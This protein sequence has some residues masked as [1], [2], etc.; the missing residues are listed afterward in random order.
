[1]GRR[2][3]KNWRAHVAFAAIAWDTSHSS[4]PA[5]RLTG[6]DIRQEKGW[7]RRSALTP[8]PL[9]S[10]Q[11]G[12]KGSSNGVNGNILRDRGGLTTRSLTT[13]GTPFMPGPQ[14]N[15]AGRRVSPLVAHACSGNAVDD[16]PACANSLRSFPPLADR[17][18]LTNSAVRP[19]AGRTA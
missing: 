4:L 3:C 13:G 10:R 19:W 12:F 16:Q 6:G 11:S 15:A 14:G 5:H 1:M 2:G 7:T 17:A 8:S 18:R 9:S